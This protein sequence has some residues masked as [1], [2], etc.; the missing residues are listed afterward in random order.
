VNVDRFSSTLP[1]GE[2]IEVGPMWCAVT[3]LER[4]ASVPWTVTPG[5]RAGPLQAGSRMDRR[6]HAALTSDTSGER[7]IAA[8]RLARTTNL[9]DE[10]SPFASPARYCPYELSAVIVKADFWAR[11]FLSVRSSL[12]CFSDLSNDSLGGY[13]GKSAYG[14]VRNS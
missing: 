6:R 4:S 7:A 10:A 2:G 11:E 9:L 1:D 8:A 13:G 14:V 3:M 5:K 12:V